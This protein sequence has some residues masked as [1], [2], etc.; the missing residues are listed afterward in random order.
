MVVFF[1]VVMVFAH[2]D[3]S[4]GV[5][6]LVVFFCHGSH[7]PPALAF[8]CSCVPGSHGVGWCVLMV[9]HGLLSFFSTYLLQL[10]HLHHCTC[11]L[12]HLPPAP[13]PHPTCPVPGWMVLVPTWCSAAHCPA[14]PHLP[15]TDLRSVLD[16]CVVPPV[17]CYLHLH[18]HAP[19]CPFAAPRTCR[20]RFSTSHDAHGP[21]APCSCRP[22]T[23]TTRHAPPPAPT[24]APRAARCAAF[25]RPARAACHRAATTA[26]P[27]QV[28]VAAPRRAH[29][30]PAHIPG[31]DCWL[32][33]CAHSVLFSLLLSSFGHLM[34]VAVRSRCPRAAWR[35][36]CA[37][38]R[39]ARARARA[40][41]SCC[42]F[43]VLM[44]PYFIYL[45][46]V[47]YC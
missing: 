42:Q 27:P 11:V 21:F 4:H 41:F 8:W 29:H 35:H 17:L 39:A 19:C 16:W 6:L 24:P 22:R 36:T 10:F 44:V 1:L 47:V 34:V 26:T 30:L 40:P 28:T 9:P 12:L 38:V 7:A 32:M 31:G 25:V 45:L 13:P 20:A 37:D 33:G 2:G 43:P 15:P 23:A 5:F 46:L 14:F 3:F 18:T